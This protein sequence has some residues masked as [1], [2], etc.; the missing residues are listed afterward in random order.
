MRNLVSI[1]SATLH[2]FYHTTLPCQKN[3]RELLPV[4]ILKSIDGSWNQVLSPLLMD[5]VLQR[6][7]CPEESEVKDIHVRAVRRLRHQ[8]NNSS[9]FREFRFYKRVIAG[10]MRT[11]VENFASGST[12]KC[13][14]QLLLR[15]RWPGHSVTRFCWSVLLIWSSKVYQQKK[16]QK[17]KFFTF[18]I[19]RTKLFFTAWMFG[20]KRL[21][22][23]YYH[24]TNYL[25]INSNLLA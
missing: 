24:N 13:W 21:I 19:F 5:L 18:R 3:V 10:N 16:N 4:Q 25:P 17:I 1:S 14:L 22:S 9:V 15:T 12:K 20:Q 23:D 7:N 2:A 8:F 6:L 11:L